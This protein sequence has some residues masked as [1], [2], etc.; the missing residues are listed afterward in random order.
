MKAGRGGNHNL[1]LLVSTAEVNASFVDA[2]QEQVYI[3]I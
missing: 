1:L 2:G 3:K